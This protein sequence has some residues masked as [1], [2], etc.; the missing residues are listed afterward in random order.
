MRGVLG[1]ATLPLTGLQPVP[2]VGT[3][4]HLLRRVDGDEIDAAIKLS[5]GQ[6]AAPGQPEAEKVPVRRV[7]LVDV[8]PWSADWE[9]QGLVM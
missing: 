7:I 5:A 1:F 6:N 9:P 4:R 3:V 2:H 8:S